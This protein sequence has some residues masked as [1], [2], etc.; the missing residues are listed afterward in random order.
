MPM[1]YPYMVSPPP[2]MVPGPQPPSF[3]PPA[4]TPLPPISYAPSGVYPGSWPNYPVGYWTNAYSQP[5]Y[6][7]SGMPYG[8]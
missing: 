7:S 2:P 4:P 3:T 6:W 8:R 5:Q 1:S